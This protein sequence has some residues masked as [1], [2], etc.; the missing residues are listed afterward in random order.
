MYLRPH[1]EE[2]ALPAAHLRC[3]VR[4]SRRMAASPALRP[5]FETLASQAPPAITAKPLRRDEV[6]ILH[7]IIRRD[8][9]MS[10][11]YSIPRP[12]LFDFGKPFGGRRPASAR[13]PRQSA[14][15]L[16]VALNSRPAE[17]FQVRPSLA[18]KVAISDNPPSLYF[19]RRTPRPRA[20]SGTWS[21]GH[22]T[23]FLLSPMSATV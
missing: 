23:I 4:A 21:I 5:S 15:S 16:M 6:S 7:R 17:S 8:D 22:S 14:S 9:A 19:C 2:R 1:P 10:A 3:R 11:P 12:N 20:I 13:L 18:S